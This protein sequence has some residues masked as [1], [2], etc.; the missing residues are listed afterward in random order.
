MSLTPKTNNAGAVTK[1]ENE[2]QVTTTTARVFVRLQSFNCQLNFRH[3]NQHKRGDNVREQQR[4]VEPQVIREV[5]ISFV[6]G[7][8]RPRLIV[9]VKMQYGKKL[10]KMQKM[11]QGRCHL[12]IP[13]CLDSFS[14]RCLI[15]G[16][17]SLRWKG[18]VRGRVFL[19]QKLSRVF[20]AM[21][22]DLGDI[23]N[24]LVRFAIA[25]HSEKLQHTNR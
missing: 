3:H 12:F 9:L 8:K 16:L 20:C 1:G 18:V 5:N 10:P 13:T 19:L 14:Q 22:Q 2:Q 21:T 6:A 25:R 4:P 7:G 24:Y 11:C 23:P 17:L 15:L